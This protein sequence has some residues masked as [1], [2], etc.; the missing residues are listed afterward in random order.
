ALQ[1]RIGATRAVDEAGV[2]DHERNVYRPDDTLDR[3]PA[4]NDRSSAGNGQAEQNAVG[5]RIVNH[6]YPASVRERAAAQVSWRDGCV[7]GIIHD[8]GREP[9]SASAS[10]AGVADRYDLI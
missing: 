4:H 8:H 3:R 9:L 5:R 7:R 1:T 2:F 10:L 6:V